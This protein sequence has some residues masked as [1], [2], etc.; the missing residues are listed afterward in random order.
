MSIR[1]AKHG[2]PA[3]VCRPLVA[4]RL[5]ATN[6]FS[7]VAEILRA[8]ELIESLHHTHADWGR[9]NRWFAHVYLRV[10]QR[11]AAF[12]QFARAAVRGQQDL[13]ENVH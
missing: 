10:G 9:H 8:I 4:K 6:M 11:R 1:L 2:P 5:H 12:G 7:D 3:W 13:G